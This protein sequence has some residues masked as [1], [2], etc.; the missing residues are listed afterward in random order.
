MLFI[1][2]ATS[3]SA[4]VLVDNWW[5]TETALPGD[6]VESNV[7]LDIEDVDDEADLKVV[8]V[9]PELGLRAS[10][11]PYE[12]PSSRYS[13]VMRGFEI[14]WDTETGDYVIRMTVTDDFGHKR[15]KH[16]FVEIE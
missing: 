6:F 15:I 1:L 14:P 10:K 5:Q 2:A 13:R 3:A 4:F 11:G 16:R 8:F 12:L 9:I 7:N